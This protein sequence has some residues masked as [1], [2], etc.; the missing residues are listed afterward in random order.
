MEVVL[1]LKLLPHHASACLFVIPALLV[2]LLLSGSTDADSAT[3]SLNRV[4]PLLLTSLGAGLCL[5][6]R[7]IRPLF[8]LLAL[9]AAVTL[10]Q[11]VLAGYQQTGVISRH[12]PLVFHAVSFWLPGLFVLEG[13]WPERGRTMHDI[14]I[15]LITSVGLVATFTMLAFQQPDGMH[16]LMSQTHWPAIDTGLSAL[17]QLPAMMFLAA[18]AG[19]TWQAWRQPRPLHIAM[20]LALICM[21]AMLPRIFFSP[22]LL[23]VLPI[24][25]MVLI[26]SALVQESFELAFRDELTGVPG[27][28]ALNEYLRRLG[29]SYTIVMVDVDHFKKFND[30]HGHDAGD[31]VLRL[32]AARLAAVGEGGRAFRY[33][34]EEFALVFFGRSAPH[35]REAVDRVRVAVEQA[36]MQLRDPRSRSNDDEQGRTRRGQGG[37]GAIVSVTVS[38]GMADHRCGHTPEAVIKAADR[39]LYAA[40]D[41]GRNCVRWH[42]QTGRQGPAIET[43][44]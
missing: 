31:Q 15:R 6:Y 37:A 43:V 20:P 22:A 27:R 3:S 35:C 17:A 9:Y 8:L 38:M 7:Q 23:S 39:A 44:A 25:G 34:G 18:L 32:V 42:G 13:L 36:R 28:R 30:T 26:I 29:G 41:A 14:V 1:L 24:V 16:E 33:G 10:L 21:Y 4:L 5:L 2:G 11:P 19:L 40:K 12:T